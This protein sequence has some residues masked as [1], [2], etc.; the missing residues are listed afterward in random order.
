MGQQ[1]VGPRSSGDHHTFG[2]INAGRRGHGD[3]GARLDVGHSLVVPYDP[4]QL[5]ELLLDGQTKDGV[6]KAATQEGNDIK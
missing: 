1:L 2:S 3:H 4:P 6:G 5:L